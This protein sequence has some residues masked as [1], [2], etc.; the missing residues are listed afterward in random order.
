LLRAIKFRR[1]L[2]IAGVSLILLLFAI[3][4]LTL[5]AI[6]RAD[7]L[8]A[9]VIHTQ[10]VLQNAEALRLHRAGLRNDYWA[11]LFTRRPEY[12]QVFQ[13]RHDDLHEALARLRALTSDNPQQQKILDQLGPA[14]TGE[15]DTIEEILQN[16]P[17]NISSKGGFPPGIPLVIPAADD[18][19]AL[20]DRFESNETSLFRERSLAATQSSRRVEAFL[21]A[22]GLLT[23]ALLLAAGHLI[24]R[25]IMKRA[26]VEVGLR[27]AQEILGV[28][29]GEQRTELGHAVEDLHAQIRAR[30]AADE[31]LRKLN[32]ELEDRV[33]DRTAE[34]QELNK[35]LEAFTYSVSHDLR[36]PL[37]HMDGFSRILQEEFGPEL[38]GE[39]RHYIARIRSAAGNMSNLV[40]DLLHLSR[41]GRQLPRR[42][43]ISLLALAEE[44]KDEIL[45]EANGREVCWKFHHLPDV[46]ADPVLLRQ[47]FAN[48]LSNAVK[49]TRKNP[50]PEIEVGSKGENGKLVIFVRDNGAGFDPRYA[51]KLFGVFQRLH[52]QDEYEG[53]GIGLATVQR[54]IHKHGGKVWAESQP[55]QGATFFFSLPAAGQM[56]VSIAEQIGASV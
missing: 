36:A 8:N 39:A 55:G 26:T 46:E 43:R 27:R 31:K 2:T 48:L 16:L 17:A 7:S 42:Q 50:S 14:L 29:L 33:R 10:E 3:F 23:L 4:W 9:L 13:H 22:A 35:E 25:E 1:R 24:Q 54:I 6:H 45:P 21:L 18:T 40:E 51:D 41:V 34:L 15:A 37:R 11:F 38:P 44:A 19:R 49:F 28:R 12:K 47:V 5:R 52:R 32:E 53:T 20:I 56:A 30:K